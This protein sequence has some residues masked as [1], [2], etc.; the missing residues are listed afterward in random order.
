MLAGQAFIAAPVVAS[1]PGHKLLRIVGV[2]AFCFQQK[3]AGLLAPQSGSQPT[4]MKHFD[5]AVFADPVRKTE[6][7][8]FLVI[9]HSTGYQGEGRGL[10]EGQRLA[11]VRC[12]VMIW[13]L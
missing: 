2:S 10:G 12:A 3:V 9:L 1:H 7:A 6:V 13:V 11:L 5:V 8:G 4:V